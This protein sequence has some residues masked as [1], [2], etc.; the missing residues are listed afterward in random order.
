MSDSFA[1]PWAEARQAPLSMR[2]S[3]Q[4]Y[5]SGLPFPSSGSL[6]DPEIEP[7]SPAL[8]AYTLGTHEE[9]IQRHRTCSFRQSD[10]SAKPQPSSE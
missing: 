2:F 10:H 1:T 5:W 8:A 9:V 3:R 4:E 6:P 7:P